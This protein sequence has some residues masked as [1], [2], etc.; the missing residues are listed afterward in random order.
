MLNIH[1]DDPELEKSIKQVFGEDTRSIASAFSEFI[2]QRR[3]RQDIGISI[4]QLAAGESLP[5][6]DVMDDIRAKYE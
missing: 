2:K 4:E 6:N 5:L 1:I 3:I